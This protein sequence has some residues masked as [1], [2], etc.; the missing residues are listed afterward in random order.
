MFNPVITAG[1]EYSELLFD[2]KK[3]ELVINES[4]YRLLAA[5]DNGELR[6][7]NALTPSILTTLCSIYD[8]EFADYLSN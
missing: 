4:A 5:Y 7:P 2:G 6:F 8:Y 1:S 3:P